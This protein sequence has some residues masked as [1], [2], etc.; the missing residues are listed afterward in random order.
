[1]HPCR[2]RAKSATDA[3]RTRQ[4]TSTTW[5][6]SCG[7]TLRR[8]EN[9]PWQYRHLRDSAA[10]PLEVVY[11]PLGRPHLLLGGVRG[12]SISFSEGGGETWAALSGDASDIGIDVAAADQFRGK[13]PLHRVFHNQELHHN[14]G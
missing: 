14:Y 9:P 3:G 2:M 5:P 7:I 12:P 4:Q 10:F 11:G 8:G 6:S 1:M 13:Y